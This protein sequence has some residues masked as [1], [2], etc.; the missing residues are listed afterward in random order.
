MFS[1]TL[2]SIRANKVRFLLTG[3]AV[4]LGV[5]FMAGT[6]VLT[7]TIKKSYDDVA[8]NVYKST[9]AV[10]RS[11]ASR[12]GR[13]T[14]R[15]C[16]ARS[17]RRRS[18]TVRAAPRAS[19]AAE[20]A[21]GRR[22]GRRR[23][24]TARCSTP[25]RTGRSRSRS[26][27]QDD[28]RSSTRWS[29]SPGTRRV[30]PTRSSSTARRPSKGHFAV[31]ETV[32]V[33]SQV[34]SR[35]YHARRRRDLR[36]RRQRRRRAGR[37]VRA[38][39]GGA[40]ARHA[41]SLR[42]DPGRRRSRAC[43]RRRSSRT[44]RAALHDPN[45]EVITGAAATDEAT[46]GDRRVVAVHQHVPDDVRGR[47]A[48]RR[49]VRDLQ[50]LLDHGCAA[51]QGDRAVAGDRREAQAGDAFGDARGVVHR[52]VRLGDRCRRRHRAPRKGCGRCWR[53]SA[54][55]CRRRRTVVEPRTIVVVD[56]HRHRR[57]R[58]RGVPAGPQGGEGRADRGAARR[59]AS[60]ARRTSKRRAGDRHGRR[61]SAV[62]RSSP[63]ACPVAAPGRSASGA[64]AVFVGVAMLGPVHR[65]SVRPRSSAGRCPR[66]RGMAGTLAR[67]NATRN[68][69]RTAATASA[70]MIGVGL[71]AFITVFAASAK[72]SI[73]TSIDK[74][75]KS[76]WIVDT[77]FGMGGLSPA[78]TQ[79]DRRAA[80]DR[81]G[82]R[83]A[84]RR[85][86]RSTARRRASRRSTRPTSSRTSSSTCSPGDVAKLGRARRCGAGRR[87]EGNEPARR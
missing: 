48:R 18:P 2:K 37:G 40:G 8:A 71:V 67:E 53:R 11:A 79:R 31:G 3:V 29:S 55:S 83:A 52:R 87:G 12:E 30:R 20:A 10:V 78:V 45:V 50:H 39:D 66:V 63:R 64:L 42:R 27:W 62:R 47:G 7:D 58:G 57:D 5:A 9:D 21:A 46:Q 41:R 26:A 68:P 22:R 69:R 1:L 23:R 75:M 24:T 33:V 25:T 54:S 19:Q 38:G 51:H 72:T 76:D 74:A 80:R 86:R 70:L 49:F 36:R 84:L 28:A 4:I 34:G 61:P 77:Q 16:G 59:R 85:R 81:C 73:A 17:T 15:T 60:T 82:H 14:A 43:R 13:T 35:E 32:H 65:P 6:L 56:G 44:S